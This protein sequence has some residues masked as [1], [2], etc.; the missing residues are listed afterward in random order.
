MTVFFK[1]YAYI[2]INIDA[3]AALCSRHADGVLIF[4]VVYWN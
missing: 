4:D 1:V 3:V 2:Y